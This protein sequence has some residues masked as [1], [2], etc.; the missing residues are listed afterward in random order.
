MKSP[1]EK[2][3]NKHGPYK[4]SSFPAPRVV[5][6]SNARGSGAHICPLLAL[7]ECDAQSKHKNTQ[8]IKI[9]LAYLQKPIDL[10]LEYPRRT[11]RN[12]KSKAHHT[13]LGKGWRGSFS[14]ALECRHWSLPGDLAGVCSPVQCLC[15]NYLTRA[16]EMVQSVHC[17]SSMSSEV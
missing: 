4:I 9:N 14:K 5:H 15:S 3:T 1:I 2:Q 13:L 7:Q 11:Q 10:I 16:E 6:N 17:F 12:N 8:E